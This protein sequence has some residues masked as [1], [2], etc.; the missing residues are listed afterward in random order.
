MNAR[1][2]SSISLGH[3]GIDILNSSIII[4]LTYLSGRFELSNSEIGLGVLIYTIAGSLTQPFFGALADRLRG[5]WLGPLGLL[6]TLSCYALIPF[7]P[8]YFALIGLLT[9]GALGSASLHAVGMLVA[10]DAGGDKP[11]TATSVFFLFGQIGLSIGPVLAGYVL[12]AYGLN[13]VPLLT[14]FAL[15]AVVAMFVLLRAPIA[16]DEVAVAAAEAMQRAANNGRAVSGSVLGVFV[17]LIVLRATTI[18]TYMTFLP[19][20][21]EGLGFSAAA[22]GFMAG[23]FVLGGALGTFFGG[24][25]GDHFNRR[26]VILGTLALA[27]PFCYAMLN[28]A[29]GFVITAQGSWLVRM[30]SALANGWPFVIAAAGAGALLNASHSIVIVMAQAL[31]PRQKGMMGGATLGF[32]FASGAIMAWLAGIV[33]DLVGLSTVL[34]VLTVVPVVAGA[35]ALLLPST[36]QPEVVRPVGEPIAATGD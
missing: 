6:W 10:S 14:L 8:T 33:A 5:R 30:G 21:Y 7:A 26:Y 32:M 17:L 23:I 25:L 4:I 18:H 34:Y 15:L 29:S 16:F 36:R 12:Q 31:L 3:F 9:V 27:V 2:L 1:R 35:V 22:Y 20:F 19:K 13:A 24:M 11:S 28:T